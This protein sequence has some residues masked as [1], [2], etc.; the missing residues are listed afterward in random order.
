MNM[1]KIVILVS[2][3]LALLAGAPAFAQPSFSGGY[4]SSTETWK[5]GSSST[6]STPMNGFYAGIG[7]TSP[8]SKGFKLSSGVYYGF[9][10]KDNVRSFLGMKFDGGKLQDHYVN[11]PV[12]LS[13]GLDTTAGLH[14]FIYGGPSLS[15]TLA[16]RLVTA[17]AT[18]DRFGDDPDFKRFDVMLGGG[19]GI[20]L[21]E[22]FRVTVGY[23]FGMLDRYGNSNSIVRRNQFTAGVAIIF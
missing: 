14:C 20:E 6:E 23:D 12:H 4:L 7:F 3:A 22:T 18:I 5:S 11:I 9:A 17:N 8:I 13:L 19:V 10:T 15:F 1:K 16:S 21:V 2:A